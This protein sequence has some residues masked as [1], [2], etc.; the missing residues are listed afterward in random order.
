MSV[1]DR[2]SKT[3]RILL[4]KHDEDYWNVLVIYFEPGFDEYSHEILLWSTKSI[5]NWL[6]FD[7]IRP[8]W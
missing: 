5:L 7:Y 8:L 1:E 6:T 4:S 3:V 2:G